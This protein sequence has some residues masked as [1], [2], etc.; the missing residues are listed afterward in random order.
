ML[1]PNF[2][3]FRLFEEMKDTLKLDLQ[4]PTSDTHLINELSKWLRVAGSKSKIVIVFDA[5]NQLDDGAG[6]DGT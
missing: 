4:I 2:T 1:Y 6:Q 5:L 3:V